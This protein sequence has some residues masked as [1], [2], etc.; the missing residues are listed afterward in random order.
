MKAK[1]AKENLKLGKKLQKMINANA[2]IVALYVLILTDT[3]F[4]IRSIR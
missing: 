4:K 1:R 2:S 3:N